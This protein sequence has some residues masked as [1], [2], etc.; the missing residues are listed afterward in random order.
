MH[1]RF[2]TPD[3]STL[4]M[5]AASVAW[6]IIVTLISSDVLG[7]SITA[8]GFMIALYYGLTGFACTIYYRR[9]LLASP[10]N[11]VFLGIAPALGG[12]ILFAI[13]VKAMIFYGHQA[14]NDSPDA[15]GLGLPDVIGII[16]IVGG[17]VLMVFTQVKMPAFFRRKLDVADPALLADPG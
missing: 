3:V 9:E 2:Q 15:F 7:D 8:L 14:H 16:G 13:F 12:V 6:F 17:A 5:G 1:P 10:R 4:A 11:L